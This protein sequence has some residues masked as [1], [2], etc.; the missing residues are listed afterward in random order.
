M[1]HLLHLTLIFLTLVPWLAAQALSGTPA[2][3]A[4][5]EVEPTSFAPPVPL[6]EAL[7]LAEKAIS[8]ST[9]HAVKAELRV[10]RGRSFWALL[11]NTNATMEDGAQWVTVDMERHV[12]V[13]GAVITAFP[14]PDLNQ[15]PLARSNAESVALKPHQSMTVEALPVDMGA[16][17]RLQG[18]QTFSHEGH[19]FQLDLT[20][21]QWA[22]IADGP[23]VGPDGVHVL[24]TYARAL[25][26]VDGRVYL[27]LWL[28]PRAG[29]D[30]APFDPQPQ[31]PE[32]T[33]ESRLLAMGGQPGTLHLTRFERQEPKDSKPHPWYV[34]AEQTG[35]GWH[36]W[37]EV[38]GAVGD[39]G[40]LVQE[41]TR[42]ASS[43]RRIANMPVHN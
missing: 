39:P 13:H 20:G 37:L 23:H 17:Q 28:L 43:L 33:T 40:A 25:P 32:R 30:G 18:P 36:L 21:W 7:A 24:G 2:A 19:T 14:G 29:R 6:R 12:I 41:V 22:L 10:M 26:G 1:Y 42:L 5:V 16:L 35:L 3:A 8:S 34:S 11:F 27:T 38:E 9:H 4:V 15:I 31:T